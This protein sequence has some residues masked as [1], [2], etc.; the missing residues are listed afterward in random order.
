MIVYN[1]GGGSTVPGFDSDYGGGQLQQP[2]DYDW[3]SNEFVERI[4][5]LRMPKPG[6]L[7][8]I[9]FV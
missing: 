6:R 2:A 8:Y 9:F 1:P 7:V 5:Y 3:E 4:Q